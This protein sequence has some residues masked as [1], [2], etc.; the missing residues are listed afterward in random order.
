[1]KRHLRL[2][3]EVNAPHLDRVLIESPRNL[4]DQPFADEGSL[5]ASGRA[6]GTAGRLV[7]EADVAGDAVG[8]DDIRSWQHRRG[9]IRHGGRMGADIGALVGEE[10]VVKAQDEA[11]VV[12]RGADMVDLVSGMVGGDEML[13]AVLDPLDRAAEPE[14]AKRRKHVLRINVSCVERTSVTPPRGTPPSVR[15]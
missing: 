2:R 13:A 5:V 11:A 10:F 14:R 3:D 9:E 4:V 7:G 6:V 12:D 1:M 15:R 8:R